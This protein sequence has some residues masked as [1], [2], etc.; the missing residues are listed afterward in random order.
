MIN[1]VSRSSNYETIV[2]ARWK[3]FLNFKDN[4]ETFNRRRKKYAI[5]ILEVLINAPGNY[6]AARTQSSVQVLMEYARRH[7]R[8]GRAVGVVAAMAA[9]GRFPAFSAVRFNFDI[10]LAWPFVE[11]PRR[12][13]GGNKYK[14]DLTFRLY[15]CHP[16]ERNVAE[17]RDK[18]EKRGYPAGLFFSPLLFLSL[19][20]FL[21]FSRLF[22]RRF[23][24]RFALNCGRENDD[25]AENV[26]AGRTFRKVLRGRYSLIR[27][28]GLS[29]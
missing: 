1:Y 10:L 8:P 7:E 16:L 26:A 18:K 12:E 5:A 11:W 28:S 9:C 23:R 4:S 29:V 2:G 6:R 3:S 20:V 14:S 24:K 27:R 17:H 21:H 13:R 15:R 19:F 25:R 22:R